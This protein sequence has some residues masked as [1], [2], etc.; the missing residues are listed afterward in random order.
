MLG[1]DNFEELL[2]R[3]YLSFLFQVQQKSNASI[4]VFLKESS[5]IDCSSD[6]E[7]TG[8]L[9]R[10][11]I[12]GDVLKPFRNPIVHS[13]SLDHLALIS[14]ECDIPITP[15]FINE[16][17]IQKY[18]SSLETVESYLASDCSVEEGLRWFKLA[19]RF[20]YA[21]G[22]V[23]SMV[24]SSWALTLLYFIWKRDYSSGLEEADKLLKYCKDALLHLPSHV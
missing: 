23:Y 3:M 7:A 2:T 13:T 19:V 6:V 24:Y 1:F 10:T 18:F 4:D 21:S 14:S 15:L 17:M 20:A 11:K 9:F 12:S 5:K 8:E 22:D 16:S